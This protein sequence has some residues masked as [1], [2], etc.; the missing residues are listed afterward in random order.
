M[1]SRLVSAKSRST[2]RALSRAGIAVSS[3][4]TT[5][6]SARAT[7]S[8]TA[9]ALSASATTGSAPAARRAASLPGVRVI[10]VTEWPASTSPA[11]SG[12]PIAP[13]APAT[14][15]LMSA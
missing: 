6:G 8:A 7:A 13:L 2:R 11:T 5:S 1:R 3:W 14:K 4:T 12:R 15:T 10:A 9:A